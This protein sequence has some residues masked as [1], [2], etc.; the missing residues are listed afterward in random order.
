LDG[1]LFEVGGELLADFFMFQ[2]GFSCVRSDHATGAKIRPTPSG[3][4]LH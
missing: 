1:G 4:G 2:P 3:T